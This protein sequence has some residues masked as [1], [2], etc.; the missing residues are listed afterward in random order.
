MTGCCTRKKDAGWNERLKIKKIECKDSKSY[1]SEALFLKASV[2][3]T[4]LVTFTYISSIETL[5]VEI[6]RSTDT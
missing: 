6:I 2:C 4:R 1:N 5:S 3:H